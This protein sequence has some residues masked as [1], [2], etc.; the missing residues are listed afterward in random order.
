MDER[1]SL[2]LVVQAYTD[3]FTWS[4]EDMPRIDPTFHCNKLSISQDAKPI[5]QR[6]K[7][8]GEERCQAIPEEVSKLMM[9]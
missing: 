3:L 1:S 8:M 5:T 9:A 6:N 2:K 7:K 4:T